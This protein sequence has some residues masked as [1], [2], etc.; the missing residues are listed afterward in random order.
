MFADVRAMNA[1]SKTIKCFDTAANDIA[2]GLA[3]S[4][5][6]SSPL[7]SCAK[8]RRRVGS[9]SAPKSSVQQPEALF[10]HTVE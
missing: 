1:F 8:I 7:A 5:T 6:H 9:A 3:R 4:V 10:N 2:G